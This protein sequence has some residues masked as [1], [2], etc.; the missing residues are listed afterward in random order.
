MCAKI[1]QNLLMY[2]QLLTGRG[3]RIITEIDSILT[4]KGKNNK[5]SKDLASKCMQFFCSF[6]SFPSSSC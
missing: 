5:G 4:C 1:W 3:V 2:G 6:L